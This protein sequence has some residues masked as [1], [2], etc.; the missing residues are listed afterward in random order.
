MPAACYV[1]ACFLHGG[2]VVLWVGMVLV[3][4]IVKVGRQQTASRGRLQLAA[5]ALF[6]LAF[7]LAA[8]RTAYLTAAAVLAAGSLRH[9]PAALL[10][11]PAVLPHTL[12]LALSLEVWA[13]QAAMDCSEL[14]DR[15]DAAVAT[16]KEASA[17]LAAASWWPLE[18]CHVLLELAVIGV[19]LWAAASQLPGKERDCTT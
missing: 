9:V 17:S 8:A 13:W 15:D 16:L 11:N 18:A 2:N 3:S 6:S 19:R 12:L 7:W 14:L 1:A 4:L 10:L 5:R